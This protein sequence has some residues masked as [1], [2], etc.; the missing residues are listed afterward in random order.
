MTRTSKALK[1]GAKVKVTV[2]AL[3]D[4]KVF[5]QYVENEYW[6]VLNHS[7]NDIKY[8]HSSDYAETVLRDICNK[9]IEDAIK[10]RPITE[11]TTMDN[12]KPNGNVIKSNNNPDYDYYN[13][14]SGCLHVGYGYV[15]C[16][17]FEPIKKVFTV[18]FTNEP[19]V[20]EETRE[21]QRNALSKEIQI[22]LERSLGCSLR[23]KSFRLANMILDGKLTNVKWV[24]K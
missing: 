18:K 3:S 6:G 1:K 24:G 11:E 23:E 16:T 15:L 22:A 14:E 9:L 8:S 5:N 2:S 7:N 4:M 12:R 20:K 10:A 13:P 21:D 19:P 17:I